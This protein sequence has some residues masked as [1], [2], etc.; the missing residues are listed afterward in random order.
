MKRVL[1]TRSIPHYWANQTQE[2]ARNK[3][4]NLSY[5]NKVL[6]S[7]STDI[8]RI[9]DIIVEK[10]VIVF[11]TSDP[12]SHTTRRH[13]SLA[14]N[15]LD[16]TRYFLL[17]VP[18]IDPKSKHDHKINAE[19][20]YDV[21][22]VQLKQYIN[23]RGW[24]YHVVG[25]GTYE[26]QFKRLCARLMELLDEYN[27][28]NRYVYKNKLPYFN[29]GEY[30]LEKLSE[31]VKISMEAQKNYAEACRVDNERRAV[32]EKAKLVRW[33]VGE[34][35]WINGS[36][37]DNIYLRMVSRGTAPDQPE[38]VIQTTLGAEIPEAHGKRLWNIIKEL[39]SRGEDYKHN[40]HTI[41][42]GVYSVDS[43]D[44]SGNLKAGCHNIK[45]ETMQEFALK[46]WGE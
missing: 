16:R 7:Y 19:H 15:A 11:L 6:Y 13:K 1:P 9:T 8:A 44:T 20:L 14:Y 26:E 23:S 3:Q 32:E 42:V 34:R 2:F 5:H 40:G 36:I 38:N 21:Y 24:L 45:F 10:K 27:M 37:L 17:S 12:Y 30:A 43:I 39:K 29:I 22:H 31:R 18:F 25:D 35:I 41:H 46:Y 33:L 28:Y 4:G